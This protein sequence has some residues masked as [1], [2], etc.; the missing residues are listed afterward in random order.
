MSTNN[1]LDHPDIKEILQTK[2]KYS[3]SLKISFINIGKIINKIKK[4]VRN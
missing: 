1:K 4:Y 2:L 3:F